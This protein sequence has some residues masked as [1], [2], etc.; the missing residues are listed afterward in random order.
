[1]SDENPR[2][3]DP[4]DN[5]FRGNDPRTIDLDN[6]VEVAYWVKALGVPEQVLRAAVS[7]VGSSAQK[8]KDY[9]K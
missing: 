9:L 1:M 3:K 5:T 8:V 2:P 6:A 4:V 7:A